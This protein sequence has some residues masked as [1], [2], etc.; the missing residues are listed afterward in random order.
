[1]D[2]MTSR[3]HLFV[4]AAVAV[5]DGAAF[6][7]RRRPGKSAAGK[8]EFP[9]GKVEDGEAPEVAL[10]RELAEELGSQVRVGELLDRSQ[11][12][13]EGT[14][15]DLACYAVDFL[16]DPQSSTDHDLLR[17]QPLTDLAELDWAEPDLPM[18]RI[19][20]SRTGGGHDA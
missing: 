11:T 15:I 14:V 12:D 17:W 9:G 20:R 19:L 18:V 2:A 5:R 1:M 6:C 3:R 4:V 13:V 16:V 7:C 10:A 8:W